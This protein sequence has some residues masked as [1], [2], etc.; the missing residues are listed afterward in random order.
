MSATRH[1]TFCFTLQ[2]TAAQEQVLWRHGGAARFAFNQALRL[3]KNALEARKANAELHVP[4]SGFDLINTFNRWKRSAEAGL[5]EQGNVGLAWRGEVLQ[6]VFEEAAVDLGCALQASSARR[7]SG[8]K[9]A[10]FP[11]FKKRSDARQSFRIRSKG[12]GERAE[13]RLGAEG[14]ARSIRL[15]KIG[16]LGVREDTRKLR[17]MLRNGRARILFATISHQLGGRWRVSLNL[18]AAPLHPALQRASDE[19]R[20]PVG[21]DR[22]LQTFAVLADARGREV[23]RIDAPRPLRSALPKLRRLSRSLT[24]KKKGSRNRVKARMRLARFHQ[25]IGNVRRDFVHRVSSRMA[26]THGHLVLETLSTA[27]LMR[28]RLARSLADSAWA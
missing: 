19:A 9:T 11:R 13:I 1:T 4:W 27:G 20:E 17:R 6:Q 25:R 12:R 28:T 15:P 2:P 10:G 5:D 24:R 18:E 16:T 22:G 7:R 21:I 26:Q 3:V 23:E 14:R 8:G